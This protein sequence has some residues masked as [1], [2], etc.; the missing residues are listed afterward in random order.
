MWPISEDAEKMWCYVEVYEDSVKA[1]HPA[2]NEEFELTNEQLDY[3][4]DVDDKKFAL[5]FEKDNYEDAEYI[6]DYLATVEEVKNAKREMYKEW[7]FSH[8]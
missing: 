3:L 5:I 7:G 2:I 4:L 6:R 8:Y 1:S